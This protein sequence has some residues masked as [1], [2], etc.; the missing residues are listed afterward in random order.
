MTNIA[1]SP[2]GADARAH[3]GTVESRAPAEWAAILDAFSRRN[4]GRRTAVEMD[5]S[6]LGAQAV[7]RGYALLGVT[8]DH[9]DGGIA[10]MLGAPTA[11][12]AD[13]SPTA[14]LTRTA[15]GI[16]AIGVQASPDGR[17][18]ALS[19]RGEHGQTLLTFLPDAG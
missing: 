5:D 18:A 16:V 10:L 17:D 13:A 6:E 15:R 2:A 11:A 19:L 7:E 9:H 1:T 12:A 14:H 4:V 3:S 8:Y